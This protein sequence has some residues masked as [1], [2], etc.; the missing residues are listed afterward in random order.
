[1][2]S[3]ATQ[4]TYLQNQH[5]SLCMILLYMFRGM[6]QGKWSWLFFSFYKLRK[7][8]IRI[9]TL[10]GYRR[11]ARYGTNH[12][13]FYQ[14]LIIPFKTWKNRI[15]TNGQHFFATDILMTIWCSYDK[16]LRML[17]S[18]FVFLYNTFI[19]SFIEP[20]N[21]ILTKL[22]TAESDLPLVS[23]QIR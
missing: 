23:S 1:M 19:T 17:Q 10:S 11:H 22:I 3:F 8:A 18:I 16:L 13:K 15:L 6:G 4:K 21:Y 7:K 2:E 12:S 5:L 14:K 20:Y 9:I